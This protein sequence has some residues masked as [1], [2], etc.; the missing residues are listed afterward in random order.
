MAGFAPGQSYAV[1]WWQFDDPGN[2]TRVSGSATADAAG[3]LV[4][5]LAA[6]PSTVVDVGVKIGPPS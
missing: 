1:E 5:D 4:L 6:L 2:L 3:N